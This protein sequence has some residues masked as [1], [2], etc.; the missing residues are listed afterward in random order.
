M[1][2]VLALVLAVVMLC[3]MALAVDIVITPGEAVTNPD[4]PA[5][6]YT[7]MNPGTTVA[8]DLGDVSVYVK[9]GK[10]VPA[11]NVVPLPLLRALSSLSL[12]AG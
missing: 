4:S 2:K 5:A 12:R 7:V 11:N 10:F 3:T 8:L 9:D 1:K 6:T